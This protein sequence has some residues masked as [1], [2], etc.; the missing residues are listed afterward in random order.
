MHESEA[1]VR[2]AGRHHPNTSLLHMMVL[3]P[4]RCSSACRAHGCHFDF[5]AFVASF[6]SSKARALLTQ[7]RQSQCLEVFINERLLMASK[8]YADK[9]DFE[10]KVQPDERFSLITQSCPVTK[11]FACCFFWNVTVR[12]S[13]R[14]QYTWR[15]NLLAVGPVAAS[16]LISEHCNHK[17]DYDMISFAG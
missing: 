11:S 15:D 13:R 4:E 7:M 12:I 10:R 6:S 14:W 17:R 2:V 5:D 16:Q 1:W 3:A 9:D 8:G